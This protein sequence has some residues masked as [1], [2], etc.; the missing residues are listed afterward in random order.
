MPCFKEKMGASCFDQFSNILNVLGEM[1]I[2]LAVNTALINLMHG[3][4]A[5]NL[6][7][8]YMVIN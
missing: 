8:C 1:H 6:G 7:T 2:F 5:K 3:F 4:S